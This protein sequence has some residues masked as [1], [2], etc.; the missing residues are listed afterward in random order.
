M[1]FK[2]YEEFCNQMDNTIK[3]GYPLLLDKQLALINKCSD[4]SILLDYFKV[5]CLLQHFLLHL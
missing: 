3:L 4:K 1:S 2:N 5:R